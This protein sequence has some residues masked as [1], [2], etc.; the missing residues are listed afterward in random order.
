MNGACNSIFCPALWGPREG[1]QRQISFDFNYK[2][3]LK[4]FFI[5]NRVCVLTNEDTK[6]I[7]RDFHSVV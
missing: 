6:Y 3:N 4:D 1:S 7:R 5:Q 2:D